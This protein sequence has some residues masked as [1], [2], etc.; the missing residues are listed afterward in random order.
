MPSTRPCHKA[1]LFC[2]QI[3][4][5]RSVHSTSAPILAHTPGGTRGHAHSHSH[6]QRH[7][8]SRAHSRRCSAAAQRQRGESRHPLSPCPFAQTPPNLRKSHMDGCLLGVHRY[9]I[10]VPNAPNTLFSVCRPF[11]RT[12]PG[13]TGTSPW[14]TPSRS[15]D[16]HRSA[17]GH[18]QT[19]DGLSRC[20]PFRGPSTDAHH[21][22]AAFSACTGRL[23]G[24]TR[25]DTLAIT[26]SVMACSMVQI[27][28]VRRVCFGVCHRDAVL[29]PSG[30]LCTSVLAGGVPLS[31]RRTLL[32]LVGAIESPTACPLLG[33]VHRGFKYAVTGVRKGRPNVTD[34]TLGDSIR[35]KGTLVCRSIAVIL[36][37]WVPRQR[38]HASWRRRCGAPCRRCGVYNGH[39]VGQ[40]NG[41]SSTLGDASWNDTQKSATAAKQRT[42]QRIT[43]STEYCLFASFAPIFMGS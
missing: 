3:Y 34:S 8:R 11:P 30:R 13:L 17:D 41:P 19:I 2:T 20:T 9:R 33:A 28:D 16:G 7:V 6:G 23:T 26:S 36:W 14:R 39:H 15:N 42:R 31:Q 5:S 10:V 25:R 40:P 37:V 21:V 38:P 4:A 35:A 22:L 1:T 24:R 43:P 12:S 29:G 27:F 32:P 18:R